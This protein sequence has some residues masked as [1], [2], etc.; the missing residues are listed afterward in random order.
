MSHDPGLQFQGRNVVKLMLHNA[1][2]F[3]SRPRVRIDS[4]PHPSLQVFGHLR[5]LIEIRVCARFAIERGPREGSDVRQSTKYCK[6]YPPS[7]S[8]GPRMFAR[9]SRSAT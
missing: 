1:L 3:E 7:T 2:L 4:S 5:E 9:N 8:V 6:T